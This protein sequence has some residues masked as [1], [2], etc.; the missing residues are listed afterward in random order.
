[1]K[2]AL[3]A[4]V[5]ALAVGCATGNAEWRRDSYDDTLIWVGAGDGQCSDPAPFTSLRACL[6]HDAGYELGRRSRCRED[7]EGYG[8]EQARLVADLV[9]AQ[10]LAQDGYPEFWVMTYF[11]AVRLGAWPSWYRACEVSDG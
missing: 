7:S 8:S 9:L 6:L 2:S 3:L 10:Q 5:A 1:M 4:L 11:W